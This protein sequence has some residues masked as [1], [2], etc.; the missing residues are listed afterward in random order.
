MHYALNPRTFLFSHYFYTGL[1]IAVG[2]IGLTL[3]ALYFTN[4]PVAM[5]VCVGALCT[6]FMDLPSPLRHK[7]HE[8]LA[9]VLFCSVVSLVITLCAPI[10]WLLGVMLVLVSFIASMM[11]I[12]GRKTM[13]LQFAA[14]LIMTLSM[15]NEL[16]AGQAV[17]H[18]LL[19]LAGAS[20][21]LAYAMTA[22]WV[23]RFRIK[24]QVLA[25]AL[26][27]LA[28]YI[29]I[30]SGFYD[31]HTDLHEQFNL[32]V[33]QQSVLAERQQASRDMIL[34]GNPDARD[35]ISVQVH[36]GMLDLYELVLA[37]HADFALLHKHLADADILDVLHSMARK[38]AQDTESIAFAVTRARPSFSSV[39]YRPERQAI[40]AEIARLQAADPN[41]E[42]LTLLRT[43]FNKLN[44]VA[45]TIAKLHV[46]TQKVD[47]E[48]PIVPGVDM[49]PFL[50]QQKY[51]LGVLLSNLHWQS[52]TF[53]F[54]L[55]LSM[56]VAFGLLVAEHLPYASHGYWIVLTIVI[57]LKPTFSMTK[58][59]R[60]D[61]LI[62][63]LIGCVLTAL[64]LHYV[65]A[66]LALLGFLFLATVGVPSF[67]YVKYRYAAVFASMQI[68]LQIALLAPGSH[69]VIG[70]R[71]LDTVIGVA[72][73][74][75][76]SFVLPSWEY[77]ALPELIR[78]VLEANRRYLGATS[79]LLTGKVGD[80]FVY[81]IC[82]KRFFDS[83]GSL[84][85]ALVRMLDEPPSKHHAVED[86]HLFIVDNYLVAAHIAALRLLLRRH[87]QGL[88]RELVSES[89]RLSFAQAEQVLAGAEAAMAPPSDP[90]AVAW[91]GWSLLLRRQA[92]L[93]ADADKIAMRGALIERALARAA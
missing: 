39:D 87:L 24:Q 66:P 12:Y 34:R 27:E 17:L 76:F 56:A 90:D 30:K 3:L 26:F 93:Q 51:E 40:E 55:R 7:F 62:G 38:A 44:S 43:S 35:M 67:L 71:L 78:N 86:I 6:S 10:H 77:R 63:T 46:A 37:T 15:E 2:V 82:R 25:E 59:R 84:G 31:V 68:L 69:H 75:L 92:L 49:T 64:I 50:S 5:T 11:V 4:L 74:S 70:E 42:A 14:L 32:L 29:E 13:P 61:R 16:S 23:F 89:L 65:H 72:I 53:R 18:S 22:A 85:A 60:G 21:Y 8:M 9:C 54:A 80:D 73:A 79:D 19:F 47:G 91:S 45:D 48:L 88:P 20:A 41:G 57:V 52:P 1:R 83:V 58:Q 81:R 28:K 33:R 36:Y